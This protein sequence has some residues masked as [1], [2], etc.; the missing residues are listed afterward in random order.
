[1][2][3]HTLPPLQSESVAHAVSAAE[4]DMQTFCGES[5]VARKQPSPWFVLHLLSSVQKSGHML[6][7][8]HALP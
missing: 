2:P 8:A 1:M 7:V 6:P 5:T 4:G 3:Q